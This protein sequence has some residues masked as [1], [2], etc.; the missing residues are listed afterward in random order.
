MD[1]ETVGQ[2]EN[3]PVLYVAGRDSLYCKNTILPFQKIKSIIEGGEDR[4]YLSDKDMVV[5]K[6]GCMITLGCLCTS[7]SNCQDIIKKVEKIR[8]H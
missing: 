1:H 6:S 7:E 8:K 3:Y 2:I 5:S 4:V